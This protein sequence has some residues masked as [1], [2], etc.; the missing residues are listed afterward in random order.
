MGRTCSRSKG[1][2]D[3]SRPVGPAKDAKEA[4]DK[5][6]VF[7]GSADGSIRQWTLDAKNLDA[8]QQTREIAAGGPVVG[9][10]VRPDGL[11]LASVGGTNLV[12]L[13]KTADG[14]P[15]TGADNKPLP[16][17][18][19][20]VRA[21]ARA[22]AAQRMVDLL[23]AQLADT[24]KA[25]TDAEAK[26]AS[27]AEDGRRPPPPPKETAVKAIG[28]KGRSGQSAWWRPRKRPTKP[29]PTLAA[30]LKT[31]Q[32]GR[33]PIPAGAGK[34][35]A[36]C[37]TEKLA[38][39]AKKLADDTDTRSK[40]AEAAVQGR[41]GRADQGTK[42]SR[43][44]R[45]SQP[46]CRAFGLRRPG[47]PH[48]K[49]VEALP[50]LQAATASTEARLA[51]ATAKSAAAAQQATALEAPLRTVAY[52]AD[53]SQLVV[54]GDNKTVYTF[55]SSTGLALDSF[56][57]HAGPVLAVALAAGGNPVS[58]GADKAVIVWQPMP[59]WQLE[60]TIGHVDDPSI[61]VDR[62][63]ALGVRSDRHAA[64]HRRRR[65]FAVGRT[66]AVERGRRQT[67]P[68][69]HARPQRHGVWA[70]FFARRNAAGVGSGRPDR[71]SVRGR[72]RRAGQ[73]VRGTHASRAR[74][75][76]ARRWQDVGQCRRRLRDQVLG[77]CLGRSV[78]GDARRWKKRRPA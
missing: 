59:T 67:G 9:L 49:A 29:W 76:L 19:G 21:A 31:A 65:A 23:T 40:A 74:R 2:R 6:V 66:E 15:W 75:R 56:E 62:V 38:E 17:M 57:G 53:G 20:D 32:D 50:A 22:A 18:K 10:A 61:L 30:L 26:I 25:I 45:G 77:L 70:R 13:W 54:G 7:S 28:R 36:K 12:K 41:R 73:F 24:K 51:D 11:Q 52:S 34:R 33:D 39:T 68:H 69:D 4:K 37:R 14:Q 3:R 46:G 63:L 78:A 8:G 58:I 48:A 16:E 43:R 64:G 42:G 72:Q 55:N 5:N 60:R 44:G 1:T 47:D 27:T 71:Q 35:S